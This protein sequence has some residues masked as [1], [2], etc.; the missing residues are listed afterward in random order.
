MENELN[1]FA[2]LAVLVALTLC[3]V[4]YRVTEN[5]KLLIKEG[6]KQVQKAG[7]TETYWTK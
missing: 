2:I 6:Y 4:T 5:T 1:G 3:F 7:T